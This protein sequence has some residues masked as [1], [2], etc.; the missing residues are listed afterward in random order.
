MWTD[1]AFSKNCRKY[2][3]QIITVLFANALQISLKLQD[4]RHSRISSTFTA[5]LQHRY[6]PDVGY[7]YTRPRFLTPA[8]RTHAT[9]TSPRHCPPLWQK[10]RML[11]YQPPESPASIMAMSQT[12]HMASL[13]CDSHRANHDIQITA[14]NIACACDDPTKRCEMTNGTIFSYELPLKASFRVFSI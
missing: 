13:P 1:H 8:H 14:T 11:A 9:T 2:I 5:S 3:H 6:Q 12:V 7:N 4:R 10:R